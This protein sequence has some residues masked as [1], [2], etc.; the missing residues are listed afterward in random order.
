MPTSSTPQPPPPPLTFQSPPP[1]PPSPT[2][3]SHHPPPSTPP[4]PQPPPPP[5]PSTI[6]GKCTATRSPTAGATP[7]TVAAANHFA[8]PRKR[9][10]TQRPPH[11]TSRAT[12]LTEGRPNTP[13]VGIN[14]GINSRRGV[15]PSKP[16]PPSPITQHTRSP[17]CGLSGRRA[18][19]VPARAAPQKPLQPPRAAPGPTPFRRSSPSR[20]AAAHQ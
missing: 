7:L 20:A 13:P 16:T 18:T 5:P 2:P 3:L 8:A 15:S 19:P 11:V 1:N 14:Q 9:T 12:E 6:P 17:L 4:P 10:A